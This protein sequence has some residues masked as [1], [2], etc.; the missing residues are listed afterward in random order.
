MV[1]IKHR[2]LLVNVLYPDPKTNNVKLPDQAGETSFSIQFQQPSSD[3]LTVKA[4]LKLVRDGVADL[5]GD[6][7]SGKVS[8][9]LQGGWCGFSGWSDRML[10]QLH[11]Q[12]LVSS[13][14]Y[15]HHPRL[16]RP[17]PP[18]MGSIKLCDQPAQAAESALRLPGC[19]SLRH[20]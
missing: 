4:L 7:G 11:S 9:S 6:Y 3:N 18:S 5:F 10:M 12:I 1:R 13:N 16:A 15:G 2:Y 14:K 20:D 19:E 17:L 8:A